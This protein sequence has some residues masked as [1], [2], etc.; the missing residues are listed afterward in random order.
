[1]YEAFPYP[2]PAVGDSLIE[3][4]ANS[5]HSLF[6]Q[7]S[8]SGKRILDAGCGTGHRLIA[9]ARRYP[10]ACF[11][12]VDMTAA[13]LE[14]AR[15]LAR[16]HGLSNVELHRANLLDYRPQQTFDI[17]VSTGVIHHFEN[18]GRGLAAL[19]SCLADGG[20]ISIWH[21]HTL[22]EHQRLLDREL[23]R[24]LWDPTSGFDQ[25]LKLM[26]GLALKLE[27][28]RY[29]TSSGQA[30]K[31][32]SQLSIDVDAYLHPIV[33]AY[34]FEQAIEMFRDSAHLSWAAINNI[35][36][37]NASKLVDLQEVETGELRQLCQT[38]DELFDA[39]SLRRRFRQLNLVERLRVLEIKVRPTGFM[40]VGGRDASYRQLSSRV[41]SNVIV[42]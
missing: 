4:L 30:K 10:A 36:L 6:G 17:I 28:H 25:G 33:N 20:I 13:S 18:P 40:I 34:R 37:V 5:L 16:K 32:I 3:D 11:V 2:S 14:V 12:G 15:V 38:V 42:I 27:T 24:T 26:Q 23:L 8:L 22:G 21:Y 35:N 9:A 1:M 41:Q 19:A 29:G 31:E 7:D 39:D